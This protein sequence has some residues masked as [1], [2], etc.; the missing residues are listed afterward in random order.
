MNQ[1]TA[2]RLFQPLPANQLQGPIQTNCSVQQHVV[3][4]VP[5]KNKAASPAQVGKYLLIF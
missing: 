4:N 5:S 1:K 2:P 3:A